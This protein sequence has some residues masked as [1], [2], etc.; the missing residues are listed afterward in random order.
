MIQTKI[1]TGNRSRDPALTTELR[2]TL[3][4]VRRT[5]LLVYAAISYLS[6]PPSLT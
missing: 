2:R 1:R 5:L 6:T 4:Y 3:T